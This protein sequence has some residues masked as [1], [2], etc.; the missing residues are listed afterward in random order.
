MGD[1]HLDESFKPNF[2]TTVLV[3]ETTRPQYPLG[4]F[5]LQLVIIETYRSL[6][7][8]QPTHPSVTPHS[9]SDHVIPLGL[10]FQK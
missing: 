8:Q 10:R 4:H 2:F 9:F 7:V 5:T 1:L 3:L 6:F